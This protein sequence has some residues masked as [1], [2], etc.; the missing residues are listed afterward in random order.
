MGKRL[1]GRVLKAAASCAATGA[2]SEGV[3][4]PPSL[5]IAPHAARKLAKRVR[6]LEGVSRSAVALASKGVA[7][8]RRKKGKTLQNLRGL[9]EALN[10]VPGVLRSEALPLR[11]D[12]G[13][14]TGKPTGE[15]A[16]GAGAAAASLLQSN[17]GAANSLCSRRLP[18]VRERTS[19]AEL[20]TTA[21]CGGARGASLRCCARGRGLRG[22]AD[23]G[24][25]EPYHDD[26]RRR[27]RGRRGGGAARR[28]RQRR[29]RQRRP[30]PRQR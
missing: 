29:R 6:F 5:A 21:A 2:A 28:L 18:P 24:G 7:K 13:E 22:I 19:F 1:A 16:A 12:D 8:P 10:E 23:T 27:W 17:G 11:G 20:A 25:D 14:P 15:P 4:P 30:F 9:A 26:A 3:E